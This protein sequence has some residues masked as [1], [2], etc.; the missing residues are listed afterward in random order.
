MRHIVLIAALHCLAATLLPAQQSGLLLGARV[1]AGYR[2]YWIT[3]GAT[4]QRVDSGPDLIVPGRH[5]FSR[6]CTVPFHQLEEGQLYI[7]DSLVVARADLPRGACALDDSID[8]AV[9][10]SSHCASNSELLITFAGPAALGLES[11][12]EYNCGAHPDGT[13]HVWLQRLEGDTIPFR[14]ALTRAQRDRWRARADAAGEKQFADFGTF[15][16]GTIGDGRANLALEDV[17][18]IERAGGRWQAIGTVTCSPHVACGSLSFRL[19]VP[20][21]V[22]P[23]TLTGHDALR[24]RFASI[25]ARFPRATDAF[26]SPSG[27]VIAVVDADTLRV[28][29][30]KSGKL[31]SPVMSIPFEGT[32]VMIEWATVRF[33][34]RWDQQLSSIFATR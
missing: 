12:A 18:G 27:D 2:T 21:F 23:R 20:G 4:T 14:A 15:N 19:S 11:S 29:V 22:L 17:L 9:Y 26:S 3:P 6:V 8:E 31:R 5:G 34:S 7:D 1:S 13:A 32:V 16:G 25:V 30:P 10:D 24:P 33:V 28:F